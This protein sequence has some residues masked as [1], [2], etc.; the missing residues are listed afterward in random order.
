[1]GSPAQHT[2]SIN[3]AESNESVDGL[4]SS[5]MN[6][7]V[8]G[9]L[10]CVKE[11]RCLLALEKRVRLFCP[12]ITGDPWEAAIHVR[13]AVNVLLA[14]RSVRSYPVEIRTVPSLNKHTATA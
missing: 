13:S 1:M 14:Q 10:G 5:P 8:E 6:D 3:S 12:E 4:I 7:R 11:L 9:S 2:A